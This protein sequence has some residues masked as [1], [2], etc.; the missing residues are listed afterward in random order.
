MTVLGIKGS[1]IWW[2]TL[3]PL[4]K[5]HRTTISQ[6][7]NVTD[8]VC[9]ISDSRCSCLAYFSTVYTQHNNSVAYNTTTTK[10]ASYIK[11]FHSLQ[12]DKKFQQFNL[13]SALHIR[14]HSFCL[15]KIM[16][17]FFWK[18]FIHKYKTCNKHKF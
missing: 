13:S 5:K 17:A 8:E 14:G 1:C 6:T 18:Q 15:V 16:R 11:H 12:N 7:N 9:V 4:D 2:E 3:P 10:V